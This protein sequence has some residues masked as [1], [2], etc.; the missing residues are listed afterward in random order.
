MGV[1]GFT[2]T[3]IVQ[4]RTEYVN[5]RTELCESIYVQYYQKSFIDRKESMQIDGMGGF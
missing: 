1:S 2:N 4:N 3:G 5:E